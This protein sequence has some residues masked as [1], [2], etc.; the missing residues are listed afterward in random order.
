MET[1]TNFL[2]GSSTT[3][4]NPSYSTVGKSHLDYYAGVTRQT[5]VEDIERLAKECAESDL[6]LAVATFFQKRDCREGSGERKPFILSMVMIP[7]ELRYHLYTL[8]PEYGYWKDLNSLARHIPQDQDFIAHLLSYQLLKNIQN[9]GTTDCDR[10]L[11]KWLPTEGQKDDKNWNAVNKIIEAFNENCKIHIKLRNN[12]VEIVLKDFGQRLSKL[13]EKATVRLAS[14][15]ELVIGIKGDV[16]STKVNF[17]LNK[18]QHI[19][20]TANNLPSNIVKLNKSGYRKWCSFARAYYEVIEHFKSTNDWKLINYS[21]VP[22]IAF[23]RTKKQFEKHDEQRFKQFIES[24]KKGET[25]INVGRLMPYELVAQDSS[26]IRDEQWKQIVKE[27]RNF[28]S[29]ISEDRIFHPKNSIHVADVS[30]SML[31]GTPVPIHVSLS[32]VF[33]M[34][35]VSGKPMFTFSGEPKK[36]EPT[37]ETL[38]EAQKMVKDANYNTDFR[39]LID[40]IHT[41]KDSPKVIYIYT[42]GGFDKMCKESPTTAIDYIKKKFDDPP[43]IIFWNVSGNVKDFTVNTE[44]KGVVQLAGFSKDVYKIFTRLTSIDEINP[45]EFFR[46]AVLNER[47]H[48]VLKIYDEWI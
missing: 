28:Y 10:N 3:N 21:A 39:K 16:D 37:W 13:A 4:G 42:D 5:S 32:L 8:V 30:A 34:S 6:R 31:S 9:F 17:L 40:R 23:D 12:I 35:E 22:S 18:Y 19:L 2:F 45:E 47:Y 44:H 14:N 15:G 38:T 7:Q 29:E 24:V 48:P 46:K 36:Y 27:T 33:L 41:E 11:E 43:I 26:D 1:V 25:T 20:N